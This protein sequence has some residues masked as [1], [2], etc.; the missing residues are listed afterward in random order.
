MT[1]AII[2]MKNSRYHPNP[3]GILTFDRATRLNVIGTAR[4]NQMSDPKP[5]RYHT[6]N[7]AKAT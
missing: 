6:G 1:Q 3:R 4:K 2:Q 5:S 7:P